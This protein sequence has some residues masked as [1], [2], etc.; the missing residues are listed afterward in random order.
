M[1]Q[2]PRNSRTDELLTLA[3]NRSPSEL[4]RRITHL[5]GEPIRK[6]LGLSQGSI[7]A[8]IAAIAIAL[9]SPVLGQSKFDL[10]TADDAST[11]QDDNEVRQ[12]NLQKPFEPVVHGPDGKPVPQ[13][14]VEV[15]SD[16]KPTARARAGWKIS[17]GFD[18]R[19][20]HADRRTRSVGSRIAVA[21]DTIHRSAGRRLVGRRCDRQRQRPAD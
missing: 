11:I 6:P 19:T 15:R 21:A 8:L 18:V 13:A 2:C 3:A 16:P 1:S 17:E 7:F 5:F 20:V 9:A 12:P 14:T 10:A 4:R